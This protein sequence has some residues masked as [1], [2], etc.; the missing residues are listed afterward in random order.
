MVDV[1][2]RG[3]AGRLPEVLALGAATGTLQARSTRWATRCEGMR[4]ATLEQA[5]VDDIRHA[6]LLGHEERER[7]GAESAPSARAAG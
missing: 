1:Q 4:T 2:G 5:R 7:A 3:G 6:G